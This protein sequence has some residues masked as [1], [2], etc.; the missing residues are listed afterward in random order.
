MPSGSSPACSARAACSACPLPTW[1][2]PPPSG[3]FSNA[4][5]H[6]HLS[7]RSPDAHGPKK[8]AGGCCRR[9]AA[10]ISHRRALWSFHGRFCFWNV[11]QSFPLHHAHFSGLCLIPRCLLRPSSSFLFSITLPP[12]G[13]LPDVLM[14]RCDLLQVSASVAVAAVVYMRVFLTEP[15]K[16]RSDSIDADPSRPILEAKL[17]GADVHGETP[18]LSFSKTP[19]VWDMI[20]LLRSRSV[21]VFHSLKLW[22]SHSYVGKEFLLLFSKRRVYK[23]CSPT[24]SKAAILAFLSTLGDGGLHASLLVH[25]CY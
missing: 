21:S 16:A 19:S 3:L 20:H 11:E 1:W 23:L 9:A 22:F 24:V 17:S 2:V 18:L 12:I 10:C 8:I 13:G 4:A 6:P 25:S 5:H 15:D 14:C 7:C